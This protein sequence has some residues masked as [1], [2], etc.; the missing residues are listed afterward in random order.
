MLDALARLAPPVRLVDGDVLVLA[1]KIVSKAEGRFVDLAT[2]TPSHRAREIAAIVQKD[3]RLCE[4]VLRESREVLRARPGVLVV[5]H[6]LGLVLANAGIDHSNVEQPAGTAEGTDERVLLLPEDPD[7]SAAALRTRLLGETGA[8]VGVVIADSLGRA[9]RL[10]AVG[11]A[12]GC[13]GLPALLDLRGTADLYGRPLRVTDVG[14][15]DQLAAAAS[16][17]FGQAGEGAPAVLVRGLPPAEKELPA[18]ALQRPHE[19]DLFR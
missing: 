6:R 15:A 14:H 19:M 18:R 10:G 11:V 4:L 12:I 5:E 8:S 7:G 9:W 2:V 16:L 3:P 17:L 1:Q 13:A